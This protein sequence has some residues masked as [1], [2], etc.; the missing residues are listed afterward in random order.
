MG[1]AYHGELSIRVD[2]EAGSLT[3]VDDA[4]VVADGFLVAP[5][6]KVTCG[7]CADASEQDFFVVA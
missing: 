3:F 4:L 6:F 7:D 1:R 2:Y 5:S